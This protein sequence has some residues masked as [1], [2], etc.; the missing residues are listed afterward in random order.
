MIEFYENLIV[1][2]LYTCIQISLL[3]LKYMILSNAYNNDAGG[4][5]RLQYSKP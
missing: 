1:A 3:L 5:G 4:K 2:P